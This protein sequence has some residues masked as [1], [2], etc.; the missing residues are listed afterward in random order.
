MEGE[1]KSITFKAD[2][3]DFSLPVE[4]VSDRSVFVVGVRGETKKWRHRL[5]AR[6]DEPKLWPKPVETKAKTSTKKSL[7]WNFTM[8][9]I[10]VLIE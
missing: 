1:G 5:L 7:Q 8:D 9:V 2:Q 3:S 4:R 10:D 6:Q